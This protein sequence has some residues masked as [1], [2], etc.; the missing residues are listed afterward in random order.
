MKLSVIAF[1]NIARN[2]RRSILSGIAIT[3][4]TLVIVFIFAYI[5]GMKQDLSK[6]ILTY[7]SGHVRIRNSEFEKYEILSP[8]HLGVADFERIVDELEGL[9]NIRLALP[10]IRFYSAIYR[11]ESN[12]RGMGLGLDFE[13]EILLAE[14]RKATT[15]TGTDMSQEEKLSAFAGAWH[16]GAFDGKL[17]EAGKKQIV[18]ARGLADEVGVSLGD[19]I[20]LYT[21]TAF[22]GLQAWTFEVTGI[23][24]F[25]LHAM[26]EGVFLGPLDSIQRFLKLDQVGNS[27]SEVAVYLDRPDRLSATTEAIREKL[28][29]E[30][31]EV[32]PWTEVGTFYAMI[33]MGS[34]VYNVV[35]FFFLL[36]GTTVIINTTMMVIYERMKE[37]GTISAMGMTGREIV[38]LFFLESFFIS[39]MASLAGA[40]LGIGL[41]IP[42]A[43]NGIDF[44]AIMEGTDMG[45]SN[46]VYPKLNLRSTLFVFLYSIGVASL[47]S[48]LPTR[49]AA[50][51]EPV[52][53]LRSI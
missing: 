23:V 51:V 49:R 8:L 38:I 3:L 18:L 9:E 2:R 34:Q 46:V 30:K 13:K 44:G 36:L 6:N 53:A 21:K 47:A 16:I 10:R 32:K 42:L 28:S 1:R 52:E 35:A 31:L 12:Y 26:N 50:K 33:R 14:K 15:T 43:I 48:L 37:I 29:K 40:I 5:E 45:V 22:M 27:V 7:V 11:D 39:L 4:A 24:T 41:V 17:P 19:R 25:A 20:T